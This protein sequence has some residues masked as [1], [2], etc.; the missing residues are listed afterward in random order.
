MCSDVFYILDGVISNEYYQS[1]VLWI[2]QRLYNKREE[3][4]PSCFNYAYDPFLN[5]YSWTIFFFFIQE[6]ASLRGN[7]LS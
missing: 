1:T 6:R 5:P 3:F 7:F 2:K 4:E